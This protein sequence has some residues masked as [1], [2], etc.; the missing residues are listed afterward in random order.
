MICDK[1]K[2]TVP[3]G[4]LVC[5]CFT[6]RMTAELRERTLQAFRD[7]GGFLYLTITGRRRCVLPRKGADRVSIC[8]QNSWKRLP[9]TREIDRTLFEQMDQRDICLECYARIMQ[10]IHPEVPAVK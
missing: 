9:R 4:Q 3:D 6:N 2:N 7:R 8:G 5:A 1:C 10:A